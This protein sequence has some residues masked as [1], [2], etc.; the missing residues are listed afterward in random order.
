VVPDRADVVEPTF[1]RLIERRAPCFDVVEVLQ[2]AQGAIVFLIA[3]AV[4]IILA[5][6]ADIDQ[7]VSQGEP[8]C[9]PDTRL[10]SRDSKIFPLR[11]EWDGRIPKGP[12]SIAEGPKSTVGPRLR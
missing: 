12:K 11:V 10:M 6:R 2:T 9:P 5:S 7:W 8:Y 4:K 1:R 3:D